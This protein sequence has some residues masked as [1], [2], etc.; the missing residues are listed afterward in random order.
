MKTTHIYFS[1]VILLLSLT[2]FLVNSVQALDLDGAVVKDLLP[3]QRPLIVLEPNPDYRQ[4]LQPGEKQLRVTAWVD[5][6]SATYRLGETV[7]FYVKTNRDAYITLLDIGTTGKV[8]IIFPNRFQRNNYVRAGE[9]ITIP[10]DVANFQ[11]KVTGKTG[12]E[13]IKVIATL[14][15]LEI[16]ANDYL[17]GA[18]PFQQVMTKDISVVAAEVDRRLNNQKDPKHWDEYTKVLR[19]H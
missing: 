8:H 13:A 7:S 11:F 4:P 10:Q 15:R 3:E 5:K 14:E 12:R 9:I 2:F 17:S 6:K 19:I 18:G 16:I 1:Y